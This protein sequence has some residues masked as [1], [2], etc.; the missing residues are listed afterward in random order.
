MNI[1]PLLCFKGLVGRFNTSMAFLL[2][3][4]GTSSLLRLS[5]FTGVKGMYVA[6]RS[7][8]TNRINFMAGRSILRG[9]RFSVVSAYNPGPVV[10]DITHF[11]GGTNIRYRI[12]LRGG[13]TYNMNT[14]LYYIRG[15]ARKRGYIYGS[16]PIVGVGRL[17]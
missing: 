17:A 6:A 13:V 4:H 15:A 3:T 8:S 9:R 1:T 2:N 7:N 5:R 10:I 14:Y 11:T 16:N 12:S